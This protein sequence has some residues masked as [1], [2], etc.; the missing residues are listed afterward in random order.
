MPCFFS[1]ADSA[2]SE[3]KNKVRAMKLVMSSTKRGYCVPATIPLRMMMWGSSSSIT[4][5]AKASL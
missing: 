3:V 2:R 5:R 1:A 4:V